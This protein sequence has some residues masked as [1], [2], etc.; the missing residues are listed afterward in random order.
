MTW[1]QALTEANRPWSGTGLCVVA[2]L[3][4]DDV[5]AGFGHSVLGLE[6]FDAA[7]PRRLVHPREHGGDRLGFISAPSGGGR[8]AG[9]R[10]MVVTEF[11]RSYP[12]AEWLLCVDSDMTFEA[13]ALERLVRSADP[14]ER[15]IM[16]GLC[17]GRIYQ[18]HGKGHAPSVNWQP[19]IY[20]RQDEWMSQPAFQYPQGVVPCSETGAAFLLIHR[21]VLLELHRMYGQTWFDNIPGETPGQ[22]AGE[23]LSFCRKAV[24]AGFP[25]HVNTDVKIGHSKT[26][27]FGEADYR[28]ARRPSSS[29]VTVVIPVKDNL[30]MTRDLCGQLL[31][32]GGYTDVLIFDNGSETDE[33]REWLESQRI[34]TVFDAKGAGIHEMWNAGIDEAIARHRGL[35]DV[36]FLNNDLRIDPGFLQHLVLGLRSQP[37][38]MAAS[39][40]YDGRSGSGVVPVRGICAGR[41][42]GSGGLAGFAFALRSEWIAS[43]YRFPDSLTWYFGD[44]DLCLSVEKAGGWYGVAVDASCEHIGGGGQTSGTLVGPTYEADQAAF[45]KL[46]PS[47][48]VGAA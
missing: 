20:Y 34:A 42:D 15:P 10:N 36:V 17:F 6:M 9:G 21:S 44:N 47:L 22:W 37:G 5:A 26:V 39:A 24:A 1:Q 31:A 14:V 33:M 4:P 32:F 11:L 40:N 2:H 46:W 38:L 28:L 48:S 30:A 25:V 13:D 23:D 45:L 18:G 19:T 8:L 16:G 35:A 27:V 41:Y 3:H 29:A 7:G 43:G 12:Y